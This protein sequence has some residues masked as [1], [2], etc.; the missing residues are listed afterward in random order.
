MLEADSIRDWQSEESSQGS[1]QVS[2]SPR[3][4][5]EGTAGLATTCRIG[6][7]DWLH[8]TSV[9]AV[10]VGPSTPLVLARH[11]P[12][13][14]AFCPWWKA[15]S[16]SQGWIL[17]ARAAMAIPARHYKPTQAHNGHYRGFT[18][19]S[20]LGLAL[21]PVLPFITQVGSQDT[22][23]H[24]ALTCHYVCTIRS[25]EGGMQRDAVSMS[26]FSQ[27]SRGRST[28]GQRHVTHAP[29]ANLV[30]DGLRLHVAHPL[31]TINN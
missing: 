10:T 15:N 18:T 24:T 12:E 19:A 17:H 26:L 20:A 6:D 31:P 3:G 29:H 5:T 25:G 4:S 16:R 9:T 30:Q 1:R 11:S 2:A 22:C 13:K 28:D 14:T 7:L 8:T 23:R 27:L 21:K